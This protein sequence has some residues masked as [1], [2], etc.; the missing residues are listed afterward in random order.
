LQA[1]G[2]EGGGRNLP[3]V[4]VADVEAGA[5]GAAADLLGAHGGD[6]ALGGTLLHAGLFPHS[7]LAQSAQAGV[8]VAALGSGSFGAFAFE[9]RFFAGLLDRAAGGGHVVLETAEAAAIEVKFDGVLFDLHGGDLD[10]LAFA[11]GGAVAFE[12]EADLEVVGEG[13]LAGFEVDAIAVAGHVELGGDVAAL[14]VF[15]EEGL[16]LGGCEGAEG[17]EKERGASHRA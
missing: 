17:G 14:E 3:G 15:A 1:V 4:F 9:A 2:S 7:L 5:G 13:V 16:G 6:V 12:V 11:N 8:D 10:A